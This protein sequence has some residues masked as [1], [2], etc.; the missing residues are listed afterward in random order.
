MGGIGAIAEPLVVVVLLFGGAWINRDF[1]PGL[2]RRPR[3]TRRFSEDDLEDGREWTRESEGLMETLDARSSSPSLLPEQ[4][5]AYRRRTLKAFGRQKQVTTPNTRR[6]KG[7]FLSRLLE[8]F[9]FLVECW[10]WFLIYWVRSTTSAASHRLTRSGLSTRTSCNSGMDSR[11]HN[12]SSRKTR[13]RSHC[14]R[15]TIAHLL[16]ASNP[17]IL[18]EEPIR[19]DMDKSGI[20]LH[21]HTRLNFFLGLA[22]LL[23]Q[24]KK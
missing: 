14:R 1:N 13:P 8:K 19:D 6:F 10:Y 22:V 11:R 9:P 24:Y 20:F 3:E 15:R 12:P 16:G 18:H 23:H 5:P 21:T 7:Y 17:A 4:E 2:R